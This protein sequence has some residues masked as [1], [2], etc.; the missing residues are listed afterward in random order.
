M[1][2][3]FD[4]LLVNIM[5]EKK[6]RRFVNRTISGLTISTYALTLCGLILT[7]GLKLDSVSSN[8]LPYYP[9]Y[10]SAMKAITILE[11]DPQP[12]T[13]DG[14]IFSEE[15]DEPTSTL[16]TVL[17]IEHPSWPVMLDFMK[18]E[19]AIRKSDIN[20]QVNKNVDPV[21]NSLDNQ[22][23]TNEVVLPEINYDRIKTIFVL[24]VK[25]VLKV[26]NKPLT[27][28]YRVFTTVPPST[29]VK[30]RRI[31]DFLS[32]EEFKL[33]MK[34]MLIGELEFY[35]IILA[36]VAVLGAILL[37]VIKRAL[38]SILKDDDLVVDSA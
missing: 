35:S 8:I 36:I 10:K 24:R 16:A 21:E 28:Q 12:I 38:R 2:T 1:L 7:A 32:F 3:H 9:R 29:T 27:E 17:G 11:D 23:T 4:N 13:K 5:D 25:G 22:S 34:K 30:L 20:D 15:G 33:D 31:Y 26:G 14:K 37:H 19:I 6:V 18:S